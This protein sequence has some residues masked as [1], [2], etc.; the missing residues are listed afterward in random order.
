VLNGGSLRSGVDI[1]YA[2]Q[3]I[4]RFAALAGV[5]TAGWTSGYAAP[6]GSLRDLPTA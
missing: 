5:W 2:E 3:W 4:T 6:T 1:G